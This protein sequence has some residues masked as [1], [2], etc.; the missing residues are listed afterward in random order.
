MRRKLVLIAEKH[1]WGWS[2]SEC[3]WMFNPS[4]TPSGKSIDEMKDNY[5]HQCNKAFAVHV[6]AE[7]PRAK[8]NP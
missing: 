1:L 8:N 2:C 7:H 5:E 4:G 6:C 3:A